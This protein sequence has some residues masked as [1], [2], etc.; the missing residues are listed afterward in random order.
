LRLKSTFKPQKMKV[1]FDYDGTLSEIPVRRFCK[2]LMHEGIEVWVCTMRYDDAHLAK[3]TRRINYNNADLFMVCD[4]LGIKREHI[5]FCNET[6][7]SP[8]LEPHN[9]AFHLDDDPYVIQEVGLVLPLL[10]INVQRVGWGQKC[11]QAIAD[12]V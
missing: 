5:I 9:F 3:A 7:K 2:Q 4:L 6:S 12:A 1:S 11:L 10:C 8:F